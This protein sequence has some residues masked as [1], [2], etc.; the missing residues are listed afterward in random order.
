[1]ASC[2]KTG[3]LTDSMDK[4]IKAHEVRLRRLAE[5]MGFYLKKSRSRD[6]RARDFGLYLIFNPENGKFV[7]FSDCKNGMT[8]DQ[9]DV[10]LTK[11]LKPKKAF[12]Y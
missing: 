2:S 10:A 6:P 3:H 12:Y 1:L 7:G 4:S 9:V 5:R 11:R 8:L